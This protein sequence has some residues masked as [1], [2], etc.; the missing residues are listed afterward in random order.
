MADFEY[1]EIKNTVSEYNSSTTGRYITLDLAKEAL[2]T[3]CDW[4]R[5]YGTGTIY[6][7]R[8]TVEPDGSVTVEK[9]KVYDN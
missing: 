8:Y 6:R 4:Y 9:T 2:K 1:Y 7:C 5:D 3:K